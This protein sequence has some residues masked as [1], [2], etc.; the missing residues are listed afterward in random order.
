MNRILINLN[1]SIEQYFFFNSVLKILLL[2][3]YFHK[4]YGVKRLETNNC[5]FWSQ[6]EFI[7]QYNFLHKHYTFSN[8]PLTFR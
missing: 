4:L 5:I 2:I 1:N 8:D 3:Y 6:M 7:L